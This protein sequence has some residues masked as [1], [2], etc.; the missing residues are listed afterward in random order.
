METFPTFV[1]FKLSRSVVVELVMF[2][3]AFPVKTLITQGT[4]K[5]LVCSMLCAPMVLICMLC[6][7][8]LVTNCTSV[9]LVCVVL[10]VFVIL[11][12]VLLIKNFITY[13]TNVDFAFCLQ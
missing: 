1:T 10:C 6:V 7:K 5:D 12:C 9:D 13:C 11:I 8:S 3:S 2:Q 4:S